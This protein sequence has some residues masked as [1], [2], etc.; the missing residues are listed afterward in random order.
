MVASDSLEKLQ[1]LMPK[2]AGEIIFFYL[3][4][5]KKNIDLK[6]KNYFIILFILKIKLQAQNYVS[7]SLEHVK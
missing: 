6:A 3:L 2:I 1:N 4:K 7:I 5:L